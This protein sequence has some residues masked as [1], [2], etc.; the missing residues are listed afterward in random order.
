MLSAL[1]AS[2]KGKVT[3]VVAAKS[4]KSNSSRQEI[5]FEKQLKVTK[6]VPVV[7]YSR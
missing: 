4:G 1:K 6:A 5:F 7:K 3:R 2:L